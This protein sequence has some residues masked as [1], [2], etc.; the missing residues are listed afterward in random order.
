MYVPFLPGILDAAVAL[1]TG[2]PWVKINN[3]KIQYNTLS[4]FNKL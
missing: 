4:N 1:L 3:T 2:V